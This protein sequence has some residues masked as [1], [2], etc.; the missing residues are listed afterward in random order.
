MKITPVP[1][2]SDN[3]MYLLAE[4]SRTGGRK[5]KGLLIDPAVPDALERIQ[6]IN[7]DIDIVG[8]LTTHHHEDHA[9]GNSIIVN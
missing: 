6:K 3:Y 9:G 1:I 7:S 8:V 4:D 5:P 2:R